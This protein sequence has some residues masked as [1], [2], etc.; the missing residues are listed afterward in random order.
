LLKRRKEREEAGEDYLNKLKMY[1][2]RLE[3][4][5]LQKELIKRK[6]RKFSTIKVVKADE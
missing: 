4:E 2:D 3:I 6:K 1:K 5:K